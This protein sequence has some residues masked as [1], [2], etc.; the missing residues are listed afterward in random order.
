M[1]L[2]E[3]VPDFGPTGEA[4]I[5]VGSCVC[6]LKPEVKRSRLLLAYDEDSLTIASYIVGSSLLLIVTEEVFKV[7]LFGFKLLHVTSVRVAVYFGKIAVA[8]AFFIEIGKHVLFIKLI[9]V[10]VEADYF[11]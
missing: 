4:M 8:H 9:I 2:H 1:L 3:A 10:V 6:A 7:N 5:L 11:P